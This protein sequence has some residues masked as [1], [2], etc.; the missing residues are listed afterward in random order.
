MRRFD[1]YQNPDASERSEIPYLLDVQNTFL[2]LGTRVVVPLHVLGRFKNS[3]QDLN[4]V[5]VVQTKQ[6]VMNT[7]AIGSV[8]ASHLRGSLSNLASQQ[9]PIQTA[10][11]TLFGGY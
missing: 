11:D 2:E 3:V 6:L 8:P 5:L 10:L 1:V 4:P 7:A 9:E